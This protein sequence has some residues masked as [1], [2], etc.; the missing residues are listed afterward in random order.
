[1]N[2]LIEAAKNAMAK[3]AEIDKN[4][5]KEIATHYT[6]PE[7][8]P[9]EIKVTV[10]TDSYNERRYGK[11]WI[12][13]VDFSGGATGD[14]DFGDWV[15]DHRNGTEGLLEIT[16]KSGAVIATGQKDYRNARNSAPDF[17]ILLEDGTLEDCSKVSAK[18]HW[19][20]IN[21]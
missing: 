19:D 9:A 5:A 21:R 1:M 14:F 13:I 2:D 15:G 7:T 6:E 10:E 11:P 18:Q 8:A 3:L 12:A 16:A 17:H 20:S 4:A